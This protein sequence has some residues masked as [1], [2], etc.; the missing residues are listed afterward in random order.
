MSA[1]PTSPDPDFLADIYE[2]AHIPEMWP[3]LLDRL[4]AASN[5]WGGMLFTATPEATR[6]T[7][8]PATT[9][10]FDNF[11][12][13][14]WMSRNPL[15]ERGVKRNHA[16]FLTDLDLF[17]RQEL[18]NEPM[19]ADMRRLGGGWH[20][21]TAI[22]V[23]NGDTLVVNIEGRHQDAP[24]TRAQAEHLDLYRPHLARAAMLAARYTQRRFE[25]TV[26]D[27][28][29][30]GLPAAALSFRGQVLAANPGFVQLM[31][32]LFQDGPRGLIVQHRSASRRM[33]EFLEAGRSNPDLLAGASIPIPG[34]EERAPSILHLVPIHG[35]AKDVFARAACLAVLTAFHGKAVPGPDIVQGLF[36]LTPAEARTAHEVA[37]GKGVPHIAG[38]LGLS[39]E[40]IRKQLKMVFIKT[41]VS[42]Q[43]ELS[44]LLNSHALSPAG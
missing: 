23:P 15:V 44:A 24:F 2:A 12:A 20:L 43:S 33:L 19:Y 4:S 30:L 37:L 36:D 26:G 21:G 1:A 32:S 7:A 40:T 14:G 6:W 22:A 39:E 16:G 18:D 3:K 17:T 13:S 41:G 8:S 27:L 28:E 35:N 29:A 31:P 25:T 38:Q 34:G 10:F 9:A 5:G 11:L 42:R